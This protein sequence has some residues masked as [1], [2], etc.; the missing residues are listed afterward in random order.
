MDG[1]DGWETKDVCSADR[2]AELRDKET[3]GREM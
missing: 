1:S 3:M 2:G